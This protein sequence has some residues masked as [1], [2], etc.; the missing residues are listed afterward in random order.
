MKSM[1][2]AKKFRDEKSALL[3]ALAG[4]VQSC[5]YTLDAIR[6]LDVMAPNGE[7]TN[8]VHLEQLVDDLHKLT[9]SLRDSVDSSA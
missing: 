5:K 4:Q 2:D 9:V 6:R 3:T 8:V 1:N 7:D